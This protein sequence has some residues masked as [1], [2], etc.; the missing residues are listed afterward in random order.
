MAAKTQ[1]LEI[2]F[3]QRHRQEYRQDISGDA[4]QKMTGALDVHFR[5]L[6]EPHYHPSD[7]GAHF[8]RQQHVRTDPFQPHDVS[9]QAYLSAC[10][11]KGDGAQQAGKH[12]T[13]P[14]MMKRGVLDMYREPIA[15]ACA[16]Q[17]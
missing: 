10:A 2:E 1:R 3:R 17:K 7:L 8:S 15:G 5:P 4:G 14:C 6:A 12:I 9:R 16:F 13:C 11:M